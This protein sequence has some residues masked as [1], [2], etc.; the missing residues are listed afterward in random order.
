MVSYPKKKP[1]MIPE[2][3]AHQ[4]MVEH[5]QVVAFL[6]CLLFSFLAKIAPPAMCLLRTSNEINNQ[7]NPSSSSES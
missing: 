6:H 3:A 5:V 7:L 1:T 2:S 4:G